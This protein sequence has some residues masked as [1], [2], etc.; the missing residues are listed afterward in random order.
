MSADNII[1]TRI[2]SMAQIAE[3][4]KITLD[5]GVPY[6]L[7]HPKGRSMYRVIV[8]ETDSV[9]LDKPDDLKRFDAVLFRRKSGA[10]VLHRI[11]KINGDTLTICGD[12]Q[13]STENIDRSQVIAKLTAIIRTEN[14]I[15]RTI[16]ADDE[17][18]QKQI[19]SIYRRKPILRAF[20]KVRHIIAVPVKKLFRIPERSNKNTRK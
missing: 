17:V 1:E 4:I 18:M 3:L 20:L 13:T 7:N 15:T 10:Y 9:V 14:G 2:E 12:N 8:T 6:T 5:A 11:E 19:R 16:K